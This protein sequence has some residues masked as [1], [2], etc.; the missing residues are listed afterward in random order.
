MSNPNLCT[1]EEDDEI[2]VLS[3]AQMREAQGGSAARRAFREACAEAGGGV[4]GLFNLRCVFAE[5]DTVI[6]M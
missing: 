3:P 5:D 6:Y 1:I 2:Q 4:R